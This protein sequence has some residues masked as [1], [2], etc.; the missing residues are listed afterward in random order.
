MNN[1]TEDEKK[2]LAK[3]MKA[4][5]YNYTQIGEKLCEDRDTIRRWLKE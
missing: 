3:A 5:G 4:E 1:L 2:E